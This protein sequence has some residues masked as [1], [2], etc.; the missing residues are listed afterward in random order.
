MEEDKVK[1]K[2]Y[3]DIDDYIE[4]LSPDS[5]EK[6]CKVVRALF[7]KA[8]LSGNS[9]IKIPFLEFS[10]NRI[11]NEDVIDTLKNLYNKNIA[12]TLLTI[13]EYKGNKDKPGIGITK[14]I[15]DD[16]KIFNN[17][18]AEISVK[19]DRLVYLKEQLEIYVGGKDLSKNEKNNSIIESPNGTKWSDIT[20]GFINGNDAEITFRNFDYKKIWNFKELGFYDAKRKCPSILWRILYEAPK[21]EGKMSWAELGG[22]S[23]SEKHKKIDNFQ[24]QV[25]LLRQS[26]RNI[27][28]V[29]EGSK[30]E[31]FIPCSKDKE[32][33]I[34]VNLIMEKDTH[35]KKEKKESWE[36]ILSE[37][38]ISRYKE[39]EK[40]D[41]MKNPNQDLID[42]I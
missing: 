30:L 15:I 35:Q 25:S 2:K 9:V 6:T 17:S 14:S 36:D 21:Y 7:N 41:Y 23:D 1:S 38:E 22:I 40:R 5:K 32:Y 26:M 4:R 31:P 13:G 27:F 16:D 37:A 29:L 3:P 10:K 12:K 28:G 24:K 34:T 42:D 8:N 20:I 33:L 19:R 39:L 11:S 18:R